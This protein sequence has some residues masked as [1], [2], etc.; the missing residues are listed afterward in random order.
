MGPGICLVGIG[1][2]LLV[3][4]CV[5][6]GCSRVHYPAGMQKQMEEPLAA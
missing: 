5:A 2:V 1:L 3:T 6:A 4:A